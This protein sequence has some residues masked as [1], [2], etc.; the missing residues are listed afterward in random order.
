MLCDK[1][2]NVH[3]RSLQ[4]C[5]LPEK[6]LP[7]RLRGVSHDRGDSV[8]YFHHENRSELEKSADSGCDFCV[9][10]WTRLSNPDACYNTNPAKFAGDQIY[11]RR[12]WSAWWTKPK[13]ARMESS[14][15][16]S[17]LF[18]VHCEAYYITGTLTM[19]CEGKHNSNLKAKL[20]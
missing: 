13:T 12:P 15:A 20:Y 11:F 19:I 2:S 10:L 3:F 14:P 7:E 4:K 1:C 16:N 5:N 9:M 6:L 18:I 8:Y 17:D